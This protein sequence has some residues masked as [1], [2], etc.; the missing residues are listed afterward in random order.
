MSGRER[1]ELTGGT[2]IE[3]WLAAL[4]DSRTRTV[5]LLE[6]LADEDLDRGEPNSIGTVLYH[7]AAIE[8]DYLFDDIRGEPEAIPTDL[9]PHDVREADGILT[10]IRG[11]PLRDHLDRLATVRRWFVDHVSGMDDDTFLRTRDHEPYDVSPVYVL[12]H[13]CQHEAEHRAE[14]GHALR[15][16]GTP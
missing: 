8:A 5:R 3:R 13:L 2:E 16:T 7:V 1:W 6:G 14:I 12:H 15:L 11:V 10:P 4:D 9:F